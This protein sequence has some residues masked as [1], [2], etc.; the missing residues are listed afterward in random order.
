M[1]EVIVLTFAL[2]RPPASAPD[3]WFAPDKVQHFFMSAFIQSVGYAGLR[4]LNV[5]HGG[6]LA[7]ASAVT[8]T[9]GVGKELHDRRG[10]EG[11]G[12][13]DLVADVAGAAA[14]SVLMERTRR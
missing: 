13:R 3:R 7:G 6:A 5:S 2:H 11:F 10:A 9:F 12:V 4:T 14:A 8:L 1:L